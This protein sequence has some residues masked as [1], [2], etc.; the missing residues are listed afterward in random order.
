[1][2]RLHLPLPPPLHSLFPGK[3]R[4]HKS[5]RYELWIIEAKTMLNQQK[6]P[7]RPIEIPVQATYI[8][9]RPSKRRMD[10]ANREKGIS[11][12]LVSCGILEDDS[13]IH[14]LIMEWGDIEGV[15]VEI[16]P[17]SNSAPTIS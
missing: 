7:D 3:A 8:M 5:R 15:D 10:V 6:L 2:I 11:D 17:Y 1:M 16:I 4:R 12:V 9:G 14:R 13:L